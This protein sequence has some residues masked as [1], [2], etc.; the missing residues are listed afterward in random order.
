MSS[1][2]ETR[3]RPEREIYPFDG[4]SF[5]GSGF[6]TGAFSNRAIKEPPVLLIDYPII[7]HVIRLVSSQTAHANRYVNYSK[8]VPIC[9]PRGTKIFSLGESFRTQLKAI[10]RITSAGPRNPHDNR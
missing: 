8:E 2:S 4:P 9:Q 3:H 7:E 5:F 10:M 1:A 6:G